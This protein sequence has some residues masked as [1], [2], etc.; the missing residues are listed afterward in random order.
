ME[1]VCGKNRELPVGE[2][3]SAKIEE[4]E[5]SDQFAEV[6]GWKEL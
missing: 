4:L 3:N 6:L 1:S 2:Q 5:E